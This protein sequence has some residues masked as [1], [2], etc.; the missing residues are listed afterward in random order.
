GLLAAAFSAVV[1]PLGA[2]FVVF[3]LRVIFRLTWL[4]AVVAILLIGTTLYSGSV[5][6]HLF[7]LLVGL[8]Q[9]VALLRFGV[10]P[11]M[12]ATIVVLKL[13][14]LEITSDFSAWY[15]GS[16][17]AFLAILVIATVWSFRLALGGRK[18]FKADFLES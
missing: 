8:T 2:L 13:A 10:F 7:G 11:T 3:L 9:V 12:V 17:I 6:N 5:F 15:A 1:L 18:L 4:A 16:G 14:T